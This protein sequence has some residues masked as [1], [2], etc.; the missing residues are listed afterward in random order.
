MYFTRGAPIM[1][2]VKSEETGVEWEPE[3]IKQ[4]EAQ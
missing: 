3:N 4:F 2:F 1:L